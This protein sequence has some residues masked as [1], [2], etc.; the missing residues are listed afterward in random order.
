M[1]TSKQYAP[2]GA[3]KPK[4]NP[5]LTAALH[6]ASRGWAVF[7]LAPRTKVPF[8]GSHG[9]KDATTDATMI[10]AWWMEHPDANIGIATG[11]VSNLTIIDIDPRNGGDATLDALIAEHGNLPPTATVRSG[12]GGLQLYF[13]HAFT[14]A[15]G[16]NALGPG[17]DIKNDGGYVAAPPSIHPNGNAYT[18]EIDA[19]HLAEL[20]S[21]VV[22]M[23]RPERSNKINGDGVGKETK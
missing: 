21:W 3:A 11:E 15:K 14:G 7:P 9:F 10:R 20:P 2:K 19:D 23:E 1:P 22:T 13:M 4:D 12:S 5:S 16:T 8:K 17:I 18:W 6:Y